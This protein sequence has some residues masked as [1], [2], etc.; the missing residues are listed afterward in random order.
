MAGYIFNL[1]SIDSLKLYINNGTYATKLM[2]LK[3]SY[4]SRQHEG[5]LADYITM[6]SGDNVY[7]F[8]DR[9]IYGIGKLINIKGECKFSNYPDACKAEN[10]NYE[11]KKNILLWDEGEFSI[12]QRWLCIFGPAPHFYINGIDMDD[13]LASNPSAFKLLRT[14][15]RLSFIKFDDEENQAFKDVILK[16]NQKA[17]QNP[18]ENGNIFKSDYRNKHNEIYKKLR[19]NK[20][21]NINI[22]SVLINCA[23]GD[24][25]KHEM[26]L[27]AGLLHQLSYYDEETIDIF[28]N[29]DYLSH[30]VIASPFKPIDYM[31][32]MDIFGYRYI[33][34]FKPTRSN[35]LVTEVKKD[36]A[37]INDIEQL[38]KYVDWVKDEYCYGDY[39]MIN[40]FLIAY[41]FN[42]E[43]LKY[44]NDFVSR[45]YII[46]RRPAKSFEWNNLNFVKYSFDSN[47]RINFQLVN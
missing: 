46:N 8:I 18:K 38:L 22:S 41:N 2:P 16:F 3:N 31:D 11:E 19:K 40:A 10:F 36:N 14:F 4:W 44:K 1:D 47:K 30:Q 9:K 24:Y 33:K 45:K 34:G 42:D 20:N 12:N 29:W 26:A 37:T 21:Y 43:L 15:W 27:E 17:L 6:R 32:K 28:G 39:E 35:Y 25:L 23:D 13:V 7:F 5:T